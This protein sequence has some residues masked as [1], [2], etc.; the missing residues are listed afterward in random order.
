MFAPP[1]TLVQYT[2]EHGT[3]GVNWYQACC[4]VAPARGVTGRA[5]NVEVANSSL[6]VRV[7]ASI[8]HRGVEL[9]SPHFSQNSHEERGARQLLLVYF[10]GADAHAKTTS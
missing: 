6:Q 2:A 3:E 8:G 1:A 10:S 9:F 5:C 4:V 7:R